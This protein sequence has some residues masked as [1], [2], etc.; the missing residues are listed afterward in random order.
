MLYDE[1]KY[2]FVPLL[3]FY[4]EGKQL[5]PPQLVH[6]SPEW[7]CSMTIVV[8]KKALVLIGYIPVEKLIFAMIVA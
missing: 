8:Y 2:M 7:T 4:C 6:A 3:L 1:K 5:I